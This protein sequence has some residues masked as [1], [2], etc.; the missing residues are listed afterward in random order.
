MLAPKAGMLLIQ[1]LLLLLLEQA[2]VATAAPAAGV[3]TAA[4]C[5]VAD[6]GTTWLCLS[7]L[8]R[9]VHLMQHGVC[10]YAALLHSGTASCWSCMDGPAW[11]PHPT[12]AHWQIRAPTSAPR[13]S[14]T[15][16]ASATPSSPPS[17][18]CDG[19]PTSR[20]NG[21]SSPSCCKQYQQCACQCIS[22]NRAMASV[23]LVFSP[24]GTQMSL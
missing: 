12:R 23:S 13:R 6:D 18:L 9:A 19:V 10:V 21:S 20:A 22:E 4:T 14:K 1:L 17:A 7:T 15:C 24:P 16:E 3:P 8:C 11:N 5:S 2:P